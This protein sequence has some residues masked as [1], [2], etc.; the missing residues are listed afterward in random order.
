MNIKYRMCD[1]GDVPE[2]I[3]RMRNTL[4]QI[5][6]KSNYDIMLCFLKFCGSSFVCKDETEKIYITNDCNVTN[7]YDKITDFRTVILSTE[8]VKMKSIMS[9]LVTNY[10]CLDTFTF[11]IIKLEKRSSILPEI[12]GTNIDKHYDDW[13]DIWKKLAND[14][15]TN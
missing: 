7:N 10:Y 15:G 5:N 3:K 6:D 14:N 4:K 11:D 8:E 1:T 9:D 2:D 13:M 12:G